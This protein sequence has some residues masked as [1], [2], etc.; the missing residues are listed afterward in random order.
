MWA[1]I[2]NTTPALLSLVKCEVKYRCMHDVYL[3]DSTLLTV[4]IIKTENIHYTLK[5]HLNEWV[6]VW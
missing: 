5:L 6:S 2:E 1:G 3:Q 4:T